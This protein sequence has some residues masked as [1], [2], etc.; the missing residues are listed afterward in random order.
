MALV[1]V[2]IGKPFVREFAAAEQPAD[3]V[4]TELFGRIATAADLDLG[5]H[6]RRHDGVVGDPADRAG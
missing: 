4:K 6:V 2:L 3:V 5:R 1:S